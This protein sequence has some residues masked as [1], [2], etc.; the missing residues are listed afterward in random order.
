MGVAAVSFASIFTD[1]SV[2]SVLTSP[3]VF[4]TALMVS[5]CGVQRAEDRH[6]GCWRG[7]KEKKRDVHYWTTLKEHS[8]KLLATM[9]QFPSLR[10]IQ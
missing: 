9:V 1:G 8:F 4:C 3:S 7:L 2:A 6:L 10:R 5:I